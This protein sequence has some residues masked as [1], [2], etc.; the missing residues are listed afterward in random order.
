MTLLTSVQ[1]LASNVVDGAFHA[2]N[3]LTALIFE[4]IRGFDDK[5]V[6]VLLRSHFFSSG[7]AELA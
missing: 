5:Y 1:L 2:V 3:L 4:Y 6:I 7:L